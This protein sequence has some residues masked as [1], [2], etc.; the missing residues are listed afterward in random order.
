MPLNDW[1]DKLNN[2]FLLQGQTKIADHL[3]K[4]YSMNDLSQDSKGKFTRDEDEVDLDDETGWNLQ[5]SIFYPPD[6]EVLNIC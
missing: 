3:R 5:S 1:H 2:F 6:S 4:S